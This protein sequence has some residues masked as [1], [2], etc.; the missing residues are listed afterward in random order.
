MPLDQMFFLNHKFSRVSKF[1]TCLLHFFNTFFAFST[2][3]LIV[4]LLVCAFIPLLQ[5]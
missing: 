2:Y 3:N 4:C 1:L 5:L